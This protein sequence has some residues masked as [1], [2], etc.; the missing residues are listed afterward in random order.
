[1][2]DE[3]SILERLTRLEV[4]MENHLA[5]HIY[6]LKWVLCPILVGVV[7]TTIKVYLFK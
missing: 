6:L 5:S 4:L 3:L 1:M 2:S 7:L